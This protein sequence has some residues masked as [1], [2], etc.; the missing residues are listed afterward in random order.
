[1]NMAPVSSS[2][3]GALHHLSFDGQTSTARRPFA[4]CISDCS[5]S[6]GIFLQ[7]KEFF[8][9]LRERTKPSDPTKYLLLKITTAF[10]SGFGAF[11]HVHASRSAHIADL[12]DDLADIYLA[13]VADL[14]E[15]ARPPRLGKVPCISTSFSS[16]G[17]SPGRPLPA[18]RAGCLLPV[19]YSGGPPD[20]LGLPEDN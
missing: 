2:I 5:R 15:Y 19:A 14:R 17:D 10:L 12:I 4:N 7:V 11:P 6:I 18:V 13:Q 20:E 8:Y 3:S 9:R 16:A 1:M